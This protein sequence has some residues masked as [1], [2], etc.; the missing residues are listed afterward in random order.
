MGAEMILRI[1]CNFCDT[2]LLIPIRAA[3]KPE[4]M[5]EQVTKHGWTENADGK[6]MRHLCP[7]CV[8]VLDDSLPPSED[9]PW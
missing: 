7:L 4:E 6:I 1:T 2:Q 5:L 9:I 3:V 8:S